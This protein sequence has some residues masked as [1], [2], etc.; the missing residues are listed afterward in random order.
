MSSFTTAGS[1]LKVSAAAPATYNSAGYAALTWANV[2]EITNFGEIGKQFNLVTHNPVATRGTVKKKGSF[3]DGQMAL[4]LALDTD[5]A[6]QILMK[7]A[8][9]SDANYSFELAT[10]NGDKYYFPGLVMGWKINLGGVDQ[11]TGATAAIE[12]TSVA[13]VGIVESLA[14]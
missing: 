6:G 4:Q 12:L 2:G 7:A 9:A 8:A 10:Q 5:D 11:I 3:N 13:G 14:V 1:T